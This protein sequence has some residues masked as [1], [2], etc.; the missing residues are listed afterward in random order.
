MIDIEPLVSECGFPP[1]ALA[2]LLWGAIEAL[3]APEDCDGD[4][5]YEKFVDFLEGLV[6]LLSP[7]RSR[8]NR[9]IWQSFSGPD[10]PI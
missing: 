6:E 1:D 10:L 8:E 7:E 3:P 4:A 9:A 2:V 5:D